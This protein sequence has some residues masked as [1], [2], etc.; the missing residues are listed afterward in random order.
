LEHQFA[1]SFAVHLTKQTN[2]KNVSIVLGGLITRIVEHVCRFDQETTQLRPLLSS[3]EKGVGLDYD[4][5]LSCNWFKAGSLSKIWK[6]GRYDTI[7]I[8]EQLSC[9]NAIVH[10]KPR[11]SNPKYKRPS[12]LLTLGEEAPN[13]TPVVQLEQGQSSQPPYE[14]PPYVND[15]YRMMRDMSLNVSNMQNDQRL[16]LY[17]IYDHFARQGAIRPEG[18]HPSFYTWPEGGFPS[19]SGYD[20]GT[21]QPGPDICGSD[22]GVE[23]MGEDFGGH[24]SYGGVPSYE[25]SLFGFNPFQD[26]GGYGQGG[27]A[28]TSRGDGGESSSGAPAPNDGKKGYSFWPFS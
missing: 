18:P 24:S 10:T 13:V 5:F 23:A 2:E 11:S 25:G 15:L 27:G 20:A 1:L 22:Y 7:R 21:Y 19:S 16:A 6:V 26:N 3:G 8:P 4:Y 9:L 14:T 28:T 17:P 12:Y